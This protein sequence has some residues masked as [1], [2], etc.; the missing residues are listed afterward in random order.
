MSSDKESPKLALPNDC[1]GCMAC[2]NA[3]PTQAIKIKQDKEGF[4]IPIVDIAKCVS[5]NICT[6][7]CPI[8]NPQKLYVPITAFAGN[9]KIGSIG[10]N[11]ASGGIFST[12]AFDFLEKKGIVYGATCIFNNGVPSIFHKRIDK[13]SALKQ[14]QSS[15]Y[16]QSIIGTTFKQVLTD[17]QNGLAVLFSGTPCQIAGLYSF[18]KKKN[19][20]ISNLFTID[21]ICHGVP[22][23]SFFKR[24]IKFISKKFDDKIVD[25]NFRSKCKG[26]GELISE[27][28]FQTKNKIIKANKSSYYSLFLKGYIYRSCCYSCKFA[29]MERIGDITIGDYWGIQL[30]EES[31]KTKEL[32]ISKGASCI[33][34]NKSKGLKLI[35]LY[36]S[37]LNLFSTKEIKIAKHNS[38]L[39]MPA[40]E[41]PLKRKF[42]LSERFSAYSLIELIHRILPFIL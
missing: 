14:L 6:N 3:C 37:N 2:F 17:L 25:F 41:H 1:T 27:I 16:V 30:E 20:N 34:I 26:W 18:L 22:S 35:N 10:K 29:G 23:Q 38:Q 8:Y 15:K 9:T 31:N 42:L 40:K 12:I 5:C 13:I 19:I 7:S 24:Y 32:N 4:Y 11:S 28:K 36:G 33:F 39:I 21:I